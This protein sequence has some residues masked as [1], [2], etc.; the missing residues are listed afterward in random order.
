ML[1]NRAF[2]GSGFQHM[3]AFGF[4][5]GCFPIRSGARWQAGEQLL[6]SSQPLADFR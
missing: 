1:Q 3:T 5:V 2:E 4:L 6:G